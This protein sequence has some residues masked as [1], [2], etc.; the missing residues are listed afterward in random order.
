MVLEEGIGV[1]LIN[2]VPEELIYATFR[3][4][5]VIE[6]SDLTGQYELLSESTLVLGS[7]R[8]PSGRCYT[9]FF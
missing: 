3:G 9:L 6:S 7:E 8:I 1:S 4:I 5:K 2:A